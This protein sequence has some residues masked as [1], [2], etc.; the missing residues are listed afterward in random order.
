MERY[1]KVKFDRKHLIK[2]EDELRVELLKT[3]TNE[4][5]APMS[6]IEFESRFSLLLQLL[7]CKE[8]DKDGNPI[9]R[10]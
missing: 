10:D 2:S 1:Y 5:R 7:A 3:Y 8:V 6:D 4:N 9:H